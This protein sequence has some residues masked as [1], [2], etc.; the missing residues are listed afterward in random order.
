M[1]LPSAAVW[2][3]AP[4]ES[5]YD[6]GYIAEIRLTLPADSLDF[7]INKLISTRYMKAQFVFVGRG[8]KRD[9]VRDVG[10]RLRGNTSLNAQKKSFKVS[11]NEFQPGRSYQGVRKLNLR[12]SHNDPTMAREKLFYEIWKKAGMPERRA[13][14]ANL[15]I[16]G[17]YRGIYTNIEEIDK[18]WL[19]RAYGNDEGNLYKCTWPADLAYLGENEWTYKDIMNNPTSRAYD[20]TTNELDDDYSRLIALMRT[21]NEPVDAAF[22]AKIEAL[23][24]VETVLKAFALDIATGNWDDYFYNKNNYYLYDN[25]ATGR[26]E[27]ITFDTDNTLGVDWLNRDWAKRDALAWQRTNEMRPLATKLLAVPAYKTQFL[28]H[29]EHITRRITN[30]DTIFPRIN[31]LR[32]FL[33]NSAISDVYRT[34]DYGYQMVEFYDGFDKTIDAHTPY[35]IKPFLATRYAQT[36][37]QIAGLVSVPVVSAPQ[38]FVFPNPF[39]DWLTYQ[40]DLSL[41]NAPLHATL[42]DL[43]GRS[44]AEWTWD[45]GPAPVSPQVPPGAYLLLWRNAE[46]NGRVVVVKQ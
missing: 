1:G 41:P 2:G 22:P 13:A 15:Y 27:F 44:V 5:L 34:L 26:F 17:E 45:N 4:L 9:T 38:F 14:F 3:Q 24:N 16:N 32:S 11:F 40:T 23:L 7:M 35:G 25:P 6:D 33:T 36:R 21:L 37:S 28:T 29:L 20:L 39:S 8:G 30:P 46:R 12:G 31:A 10:L 19:E 18:I 42:Y 43:T